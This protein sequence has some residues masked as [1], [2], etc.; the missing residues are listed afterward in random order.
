MYE[1]IDEQHSPM[2][3]CEVIIPSSDPDTIYV[4][5]ANVDEETMSISR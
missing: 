4:S 2:I 3:S 5:Y 1:Y